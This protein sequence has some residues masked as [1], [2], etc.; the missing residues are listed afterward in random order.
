MFGSTISPRTNIPPPPFSPFKQCEN[1]LGAT[2]CEASWEITDIPCCPNPKI[3][4]TARSGFT[5]S[6]VC[7]VLH[8]FQKEN[9]VKSSGLYWW[10]L[11][12]DE[13][14][15]PEH[16]LSGWVWDKRASNNHVKLQEI[17]DVVP[18]G[19]TSISIL[20]RVS[21]EVVL[22]R[23][24]WVRGLN[25]P[26]ASLV[27]TWDWRRCCRAPWIKVIQLNLQNRASH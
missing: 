19:A 21:A 26:A 22:N 25:A 18:R 20:K 8:L 11:N 3:P 15:S 24:A 6:P 5:K 10:F 7:E 17:R 23:T 13:I 4:S 27:R 1:T 9:K 12:I 16:N 2:P 14:N